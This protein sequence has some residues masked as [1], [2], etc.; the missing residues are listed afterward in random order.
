MLYIHYTEV[1]G[2]IRCPSGYFNNVYE[3]DWMK[4]AFVKEMVKAVD[5]SDVIDVDCVRS[6]VLGTIPVTKLSGGVKA[7]ILMYKSTEDII[8]ATACGDNCAEWIIRISEKRDLH[9]VLTHI[10]EFPRDFQAICVDNDRHIGSL[11]EYYDNAYD[12]LYGA[13][14]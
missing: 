1:E 9:I 7:L 13:V 8:W 5:K 10:M 11:E 4:D 3:D 6:P 14:E 2:T 12:M